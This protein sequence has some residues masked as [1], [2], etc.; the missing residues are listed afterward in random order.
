[1][2]GFSCS[3]MIDFNQLIKLSA[4]SQISQVVRAAT[5]GVSE[6]KIKYLVSGGPMKKYVPIVSL[7]LLVIAGCGVEWFPT[8]ISA[9]SP[10]L[11]MS[12][13]PSTISTATGSSATLT[14]TISNNAD[15][16]AQSGL[17]F[18]ETLPTGLTVSTATASQCGGTVTASGT[19]L[20]FTG[21]TLAAGA[22]SCTVT[23]T[24]TG[25]TAASYTIAASSIS[26]LAGGLQ[27]N[28]TSQ[29]LTVTAAPILT[30]S[31]APSAITVSSGTPAILTFTITNITGNPLQTGLGFTDTLPTGLTAAGVAGGTCGGTVNVSG[32]LI[33]LSS[34][35]LAV[36]QSSCTFS[37]SVTGTVTG[38]PYSIQST[39]ITGLTG[40]LVNG[41]TNQTLTVSP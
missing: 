24:V 21:G 17:G 23:A 38:S 25:T 40:N 22:T 39:G 33:S 8:N 19:T 16:T 14:F 10:N 30:M 7:L 1:M 15:K 26:S 37:A 20:S 28:S 27:N 32:T 2:A 3:A 29:V 4:S 18:T 5:D 11:T 31:L 13:S 41:T 34:G 9:N 12:I 36:G 35:S 6:M